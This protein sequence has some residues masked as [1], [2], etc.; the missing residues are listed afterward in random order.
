MAATRLGLVWV[1][2]LIVGAYSAVLGWRGGAFV[3]L[4][5]VCGNVAGHLLIGVT[6]YRRIMSRPWPEVP[7]LDDGDD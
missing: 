6:E 1:I 5:A 7:P 4:G 2:L 3:M